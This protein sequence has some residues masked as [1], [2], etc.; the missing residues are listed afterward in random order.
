MAA[1]VGRQGKLRRRVS[2]LQHRSSSCASFSA[3][4]LGLIRSARLDGASTGGRSVER[5]AQPHQERLAGGLAWL[6]FER[7]LE[8]ANRLLQHPLG[9]VQASQVHVWKMT[10]LIARRLLGLLQPRHRRV[11]LALGDQVGADVVIGIAEAGIDLDRFLALADRVVY[12]AEKIIGPTAKGISLSSRT[13][14]DRFRVQLDRAL[15]V[16]VH[17]MLHAFVPQFE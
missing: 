7:T 17:V 14:L 13:D 16:A 2:I 10:R 11:E 4:T 15:E 9:R 8:L 5:R 1:V 3:A 12:A 6:K